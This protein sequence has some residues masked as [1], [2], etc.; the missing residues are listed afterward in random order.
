MDTL[1]RDLLNLLN[2]D[3]LT[4]ALKFECSTQL[5]S[6]D[7]VPF[8]SFT[9]VGDE[10]FVETG[11]ELCLGHRVLSLVGLVNAVNLAAAPVHDPDAVRVVPAFERVLDEPLL[12]TAS[13]LLVVLVEGDNL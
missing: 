4:E 1:G 11:I 9:L 6:V 10:E 2:S 8:E 3:D 7:D 5:T 12:G 13:A